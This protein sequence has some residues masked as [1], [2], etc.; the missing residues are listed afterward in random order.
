MAAPSPDGRL[1]AVGGNRPARLWTVDTQKAGPPLEGSSGV[2]ALA[3]TPDGRALVGLW[4]LGRIRIW[5]SATGKF[6]REVDHSYSGRFT[7][8]AA[9]ADNLVVLGSPTG[10][11][12]LNLETG[13]ALNTGDGPDPL[14]GRGLVVPTRSWI[15]AADRDERLTA[16]RVNPARGTRLPAKPPP[17]SPWPDV[18]VRRDAPNSPVVGMAFAADGKSVLAATE[19]GRLMRSTADRLLFAGEVEAEGARLFGFAQAGD[20]V[21]TLGRRS[22]V[23]GRDA[24]TLEKKFEIPSQAPGNAVPLLLAA[25]PD[26]SS[27]VVSADKARLADVKTRKEVKTAALP[28]AAV[29][30]KLTQFAFSADGRVSVARWGDTVTAVW[31]PKTGQPRV[32]EALPDAVPASRQGLALTPDGKIAL[33]G[34]GD[35]KLT[36]WD[37]TTGKQLFAETVYPD[38]DPAEAISAVAVLPNGTH[39]LTL[40]RDGRLILWELGDF[41]KAKEFRVPE[42]PWRLAVAPDGRAAVVQKAGE[43]LRIELTDAPRR[44]P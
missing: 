34:T 36:A 12:V 17:A 2:V 10:R 37:T 33:L 15:L 25:S 41:R 43:I 19:N 21:F 3:F 6:L 13:Q 28:V 5:D 23:I 32:L 42:G 22:L 9:I 1:I 38:G 35:G 30:L 44:E 31:N 4:P 27:V 20:L 26:G 11:L 8:L 24:E 39:F 18:R 7:E 40:G 29:G 16:W 14:T